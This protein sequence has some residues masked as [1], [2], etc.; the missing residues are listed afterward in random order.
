MIPRIIM[1][2]CSSLAS[3]PT[4]FRSLHSCTLISGARNGVATAGIGRPAR[5]STLFL[6][7]LFALTININII[8]INNIHDINLIHYWLF[9]PIPPL[10]LWI[11]GD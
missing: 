8:N 2:R 11:V 4:A 6:S 10:C 7:V 5:P 3:I 9:V 1:P